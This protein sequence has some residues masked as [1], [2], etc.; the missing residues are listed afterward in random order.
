[1]FDLAGER[2]GICPSLAGK[3]GVG[4]R[5]EFPAAAGGVEEIA[6]DGLHLRD[7]LGVRE[8]GLEVDRDGGLRHG[9]KG[10]T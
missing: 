6:A 5:A 1:M 4:W 9:A 2:I 3:D 7:E 10:G 8:G